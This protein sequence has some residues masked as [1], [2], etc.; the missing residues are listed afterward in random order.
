[1]IETSLFIVDALKV[2]LNGVEETNPR[3]GLPNTIGGP[4]LGQA[5]P[6]HRDVERPG[7]R[8]IGK[9]PKPVVHPR[10]PAQL[11]R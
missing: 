9:L 6:A 11:R 7:E 2:D 10:A 5:G 1:M 8:A 4:E 3:E